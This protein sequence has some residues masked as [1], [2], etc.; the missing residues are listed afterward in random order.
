MPKPKK[1]DKH[2]PMRVYVDRGKKRKDG[3]WP[4]P[5]YYLKPPKGNRIPLGR[6]EADALRKWVEVIG[7]PKNVATMNHLFDRY[8]IEE[9]SKVKKAKN[10]KNSIQRLKAP[11]LY[12]GEMYPEDVE[13]A[14]IYDF[15]EERSVKVKVKRMIRGKEKEMEIGGK[16]A[17][18]REKS[19]LSQVFKF[20]IKKRIVT[21]NPCVG[22]ERNTEIP[23][24]RYPKD[25]EFDA[26]YD[27]GSEILQCIMD[28]G[29]ITDQRIGDILEINERENISEQGIEVT[30]NKSEGGKR[31]LVKI[32]IK[33]D[34]ALRECVNRARNLR[35]DIRSMY[36]FCKQ[37]G[38]PYT[39]DG[40]KS[41][42]RRAVDKAI[43]NGTLQEKFNYHD[44][45]AKSYS[46]E[47]NLEDKMKRAGHQSLQMRKTYDRKPVEVH[48]KKK[49]EK[50]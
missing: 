29:Y 45:R 43:K 23:R 37:D 25:W 49:W 35:G 7:R 9:L 5:K 38:Q 46:D 44:I 42:F 6:N 20:G 28:F 21:K 31:V 40:F 19:I 34:D 24:D 3:S 4:L 50:G 22:V 48:P 32:L 27:A 30:Q 36:I 10:Y 1:V 17:A 15:M 8:V 2:L 16:V 39:Y 13:Q 18:N 12:F 26:V 33:W 14:D 11:R 47:T 41:M